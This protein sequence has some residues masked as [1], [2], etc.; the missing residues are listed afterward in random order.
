M[1]KW[2]GNR[3]GSIV[4]LLL[5]IMHHQQFII[6]LTNTI[7]ERMVDGF[8]QFQF[9]EELHMVPLSSMVQRGLFV[10]LQVLELSLY[11]GLIQQMQEFL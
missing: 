9:L 3:F 5:E 11:L 10:S 8:N 7:P 1:P 4:R 6:F 2:I